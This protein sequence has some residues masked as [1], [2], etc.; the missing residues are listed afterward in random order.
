MSQPRTGHVRKGILRRIHAVRT[1]ARKMGWLRVRREASDFASTVAIFFLGILLLTCTH[2]MG[3]TETA[4]TAVDFDR[5]HGTA[6]QYGRFPDDAIVT[7]GEFPGSLQ[8]PGTGVSVR[9]GGLVRTDI[10]HDVDS[11]G[12]PDV[13][14]VLTIPVDDS[15]AD[16]TGQTRFS[17][18]NS[19][20]N[21]DVRGHSSIGEVRAFIEADFLGD[22]DARNSNY[23]F[24]L[25]HAAAQVGHLYFGQWWSTFVDVAAIPEGANAPLGALTLRQP[26]IRW[27]QNLGSMFRTVVAVESPAGS[28]T[29][30]TPPAASDS[31]PDVTG[32]LQ[33]R[34]D[35]LRVRISGIL[36]RLETDDD[37]RFVGGGSLTGRIQLPFLGA[38]DN[39][40]FQGQYGEGFSRYYL[41][42]ATAGLDA[43][44]TA[45]GR[46][47]PI[48]ILAGYVAYQHWWSERWR[49]SVVASVLDFDMPAEAAPDTFD[50]GQ[51]YSANVYWSP[52][53]R[54][55][56]GVD[57]VYAVRE[58]ADGARGD[59]VRIHG[60]AR[61]DFWSGN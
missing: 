10:I 4:S 11:L 53:D 36:R 9:L 58:N 14:N 27:G 24:Q 6:P 38:H 54:V 59:G 41:P 35:S 3:A 8:I 28:L 15:P 40:A 50:N 26:G 16:G 45:R 33:F 17:A 25:R 5:K 61:L 2:A 23:Q 57:V 48:G 46:L 55:T 7:T 60:S 47:R 1:C 19:R 21:F 12:F 43:I 22:G 13:V 44:V 29:A 20:I 18:R 37:K 49:S 32:Y 30:E 34:V 31:V 51:Y 42:L 39:I 52:L 56:F